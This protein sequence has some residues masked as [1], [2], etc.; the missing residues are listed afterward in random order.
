M[1]TCSHVGCDCPYTREELRVEGVPLNGICGK[2]EHPRSEHA[3]PGAV[4]HTIP[5]PSNSRKRRWEELNPILAGV[6]KK[7]KKVDKSSTPYSSIMWSDVE[8]V[9]G[10]VE[11]RQGYRK[12]GV[13]VLDELHARILNLIKVFGPVSDGKEAKRLQFISAILFEVALRFNGEVIILVEEDVD[14]VHINTNGHFE[15]VLQKGGK[16]VCIVEAKKEEME[17]GMA[18]NLLGCEALADIEN[19]SVVYGIVTNFLEWYFLKD[20]DDVIYR[21]VYT[22]NVQHGVPSKESVGKIASRIYGL[23][24]NEEDVLDDNEY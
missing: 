2:C 10:C 12:L 20:T 17:K 3:G 16:R 19:V 23:L 9:L 13:E 4:E 14:G 5:G 22:L 21:D 1:T 8:E 11:Y 18:Q 24:S 15:F 7:S 6:V